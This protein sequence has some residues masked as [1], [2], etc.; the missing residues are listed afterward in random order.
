MAFDSFQEENAVVA[1]AEALLAAPDDGGDFR[2]AY[3][4]LLKAYKRLFKVERRLLRFSDRNERQL[5]TI[6]QSLQQ[7]KLAAELANRSKS[8][9]LANMSHEIRTPMNAVLGL[10]D[11][12]LASEPAA[13]VRDHLVKIGHASRSLLRI[14][15]DILDFSKIEAGKLTLDPVDFV[16]HDLFGH[17]ADL[18]QAKADEQRLALLF[19]D[20]RECHDLLRGDGLRLEQ[21]LINLVG[22]ALKFTPRGRVEVR[23]RT[24]EKINP[25]LLHFSVRDTGIGLSRE[26][27]DRLFQPFE[28]ADGT[29]SRRY[30]GTGLGLAICKRLVEMMDG[31]IWVESVL[32]EGSTFHFTVRLFRKAKTRRGSPRSVPHTTWQQRDPNAVAQQIGGAEVLLVEDNALNQQVAVGI[33]QSVGLLVQVAA[34]GQEALQRLAATHF[35]CVLM[36]IQMPGMD[37]YETTR[38]IRADERFTLLPIIAMTAHAMTGDRDKSLA[39]GMNDHVVKPINKQQLFAVLLQWI[40]PRERPR[41]VL[42]ELLDPDDLSSACDIAGIDAGDALER[43]GHN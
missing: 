42:Y 14:I 15:Q 13:P 19:V 16:L 36:D 3:A 38:R 1:R 21:I 5:L 34:N 40:V 27:Q 9:F 43:L 20:S 12:A 22:N 26:Q 24:E 32:G 23:V 29:T 31:A 10:T 17:V 39:A 33:L 2:S 37:G 7:A 4:E 41:P 6:S 11:L 35:D 8:H 30:G 28:Q 25:L 18:F